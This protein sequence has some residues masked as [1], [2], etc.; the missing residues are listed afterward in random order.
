ML[1]EVLR[2]A[3]VHPPQSTSGKSLLRY[4]R[5]TLDK[6]EPDLIFSQSTS[7]KDIYAA[8]CL[9]Q[10][11]K[12]IYEPN[13]RDVQHHLYDLSA[14]PKELRNLAADKSTYS[15]LQKYLLAHL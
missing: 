13:L 12:Y 10:N 8:A 9:Q 7:S 6:P 15:V 3:S 1:D 11:R 5:R 4:A 2:V 14:D